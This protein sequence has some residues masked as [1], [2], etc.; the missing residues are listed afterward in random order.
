MI[1]A[2]KMPKTRSPIDKCAISHPCNV[3][4]IL[5]VLHLWSPVETVGVPEYPSNNWPPLRTVGAPEYPSNNWPP[6]GRVGVPEYPS[7]NWPPWEQLGARI[8][9]Y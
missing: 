7:N 5:N 3:T 8:S 6:L 2:V 9:Q 4:A 1:S